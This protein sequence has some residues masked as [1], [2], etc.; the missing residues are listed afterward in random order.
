MLNS[1]IQAVSGVAGS[2]S[3][4]LRL[5]SFCPSC[6]PYYGDI[7]LQIKEEKLPKT[8]L[9][10]HTPAQPKCSSGVVVNDSVE[11]KLL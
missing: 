10:H 7:A 8:R 4:L 9:S 3:A 5:I 6:L 2:H 11:L 1:L